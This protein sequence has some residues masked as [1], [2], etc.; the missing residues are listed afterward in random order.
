M[1]GGWSNSSSQH[2]AH[3]RCMRCI[4]HADDA[5]A[6]GGVRHHAITPSRAGGAWVA[7]CVVVRQRSRDPTFH[8]C[9]V[10]LLHCAAARAR[11]RSAQVKLLPQHAIPAKPWRWFRERPPPVS[12]GGVRRWRVVHS[13]ERAGP[14]PQP[15]SPTHPA[16]DMFVPASSLTRNTRCAGV[17]D[18][19]SAAER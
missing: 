17:G 6:H 13:G 16:A 7:W 10:A 3:A 1:G 19:V 12:K 14:R 11:A 15:N 5:R 4:M 18:G 2:H 9:I 8:C